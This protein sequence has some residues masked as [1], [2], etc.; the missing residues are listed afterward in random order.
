MKSEP[1]AAAAEPSTS[2]LPFDFTPLEQF[3]TIVWFDD[4]HGHCVYLNRYALDFTGRSLE[5]E[6]G[7]GWVQALHPSDVEGYLQAYHLALGLRHPFEVEFR[8]RRHD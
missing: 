2:T 7:L 1:R 3:P 4:V 6:R 8:L 5:E